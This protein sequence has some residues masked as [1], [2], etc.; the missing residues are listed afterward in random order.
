MPF[1]QVC[2]LFV[3]FFLS[4]V[5]SYAIITEQELLHIFVFFF[6]NYS[7]II[8]MFDKWKNF[9][10]LITYFFIVVVLV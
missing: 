5:L 8:F 6:Y 4:L 2:I 7:L 1:D 9:F 3:C 10:F